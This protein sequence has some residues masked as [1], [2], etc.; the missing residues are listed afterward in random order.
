MYQFAM[1]APRYLIYITI[2]YIY[3]V[4]LLVFIPR[5]GCYSSLKSVFK[6][7]DPDSSF[8][9]L[10]NVV[11]GGISGIIGATI[12]SPLQLVKIRFFFVFP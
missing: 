1:N 4:F 10:R 2:L 5:L 6:S 9:M 3:L 12:G 7:D 11:A 8:K